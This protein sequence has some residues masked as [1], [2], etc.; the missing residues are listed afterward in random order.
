MQSKQ[1]IIFL[2]ITS[3]TSNLNNSKKIEKKSNRNLNNYGYGNGFSS[4]YYDSTGYY[5]GNSYDST[6]SGQCSSEKCRNNWR[7]VGYVFLGIFI[8]FFILIVIYHVYLCLRNNDNYINY[9]PD[10]NMNRIGNNLKKK[11]Y[12]FQNELKYQIYNENMVKYGD[13]CTICLEKFI[14]NKIRI[15]F[16]PCKHIF[17][18]SCLKEYIIKSNDTHCPNCKFDFFS[19]LNGKNINYDL[20]E[21][22]DNYPNDNIDDDQKKNDNNE[23]DVSLNLNTNNNNN[24]E[25]K[26]NNNENKENIDNT[27]D[28]NND[29]IRI[30]IENKNKIKIAN[31]NVNENDN[32]NKIKSESESGN[33]REINL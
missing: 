5:N 30:N 31:E 18:F 1:I 9:D 6:Y 28:N 32:D 26:D 14:V 2:L 12:L 25:N 17:H 22:D 4:G 29:V 8:V 24:N 7:I 16:T 33:N 15:C 19:L 20:V 11:H 13:E 21:I 10:Y 23:R 27:K 3:I